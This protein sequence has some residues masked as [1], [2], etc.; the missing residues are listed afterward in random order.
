MALQYN[1]RN[2]MHTISLILSFGAYDFFFLEHISNKDS[3]KL[4]CVMFI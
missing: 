3:K 2:N 4:A 1:W